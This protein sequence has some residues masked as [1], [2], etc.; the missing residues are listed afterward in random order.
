MDMLGIVTTG[1]IGI[2]LAGLAVI[3]GYKLVTGGINTRGLLADTEH[4]Q[5]SP[6]RIQLLLFTLIG[7]ASYAAL[8]GEAI[9]N[10]TRAFPAVPDELLAVVGGSQLIYVTGKSYLRFFRNRPKSGT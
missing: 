8:I 3:V 6:V 4:G 5:L 7:A 9:A 2:F 1:I 10:G